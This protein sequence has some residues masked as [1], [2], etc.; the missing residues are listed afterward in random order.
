MTVAFKQEN[1]I[2]EIGHYGVMHSWFSTV[3]TRLEGSKWGARFPIVMLHLY[4][5]H[6]ENAKGQQ[7]LMELNAI[8]DALSKLPPSELVWDAE[9]PS[10]PPPAE[11]QRNPNATSLA[12]YF[13]TA[14]GLDLTQ[15]F[16]GN[17]EAMNEFGGNLD[18]VS[19]NLPK[20]KR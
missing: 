14:N 3:A 8:A 13:L 9:S 15:E 11:H 19:V 7:A 10:Q 1:V 2:T 6:L 17:V 4:Q 12:N 18:I 5:G 16:I 20:Q